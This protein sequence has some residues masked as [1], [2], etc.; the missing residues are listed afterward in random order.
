MSADES[1]DT[2]DMTKSID[3]G[4]SI[5]LRVYAYIRMYRLLE[6]ASTHR[7]IAC[8]TVFKEYYEPDFSDSRIFRTFQP[9]FS[10]S[11]HFSDSGSKPN[12]FN[13]GD[14]GGWYGLVGI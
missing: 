7:W 12:S 3:A 6:G 1:D 14:E 13:G 5:C 4:Q 8:P 10:F 11:S 9:L 2:G